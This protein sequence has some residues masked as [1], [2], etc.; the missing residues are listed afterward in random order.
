MAR[1]LNGQ[2]QIDGLKPILKA[3][4]KLP[5][6]TQR[7][8]LRPATTKATTPVIRLA[9]QLVPVG[10][11]LNPDGS[12]RLHL[13]QTIKKTRAKMDRRGGVYVVAGPEANKA[14][15]DH[16]VEFGTK[17]HTIT[18]GKPL[19]LGGT[20]LP[21]GTVIHHPGSKGSHFMERAANQSR[22]TST[23]IMQT[24]ILRGID[25]QVLKLARAK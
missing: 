8:V 11:G 15:H 9:K 13:R 25:K 12:P 20:T 21:I 1:K 10:D 5:E 19:Q 17:P 4:R 16:L 7:A 6:R 24:E 14:P 23:K 18:L 22:A 3:L 2:V